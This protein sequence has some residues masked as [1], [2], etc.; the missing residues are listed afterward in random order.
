MLFGL[1]KFVFLGVRLGLACRSVRAWKLG[2]Y[3][4]IEK[5]RKCFLIRSR[6]C[7]HAISINGREFAILLPSPRRALSGSEIYDREIYNG[8]AA[9]D[10]YGVFLPKKSWIIAIQIYIQLY[11]RLQRGVIDA[12]T[13]STL[14]AKKKNSVTSRRANLIRC[15]REIRGGIR[16]ATGIFFSQ[17]R[18]FIEPWIDVF[19]WELTANEVSRARPFREFKLPRSRLSYKLEQTVGANL[20][21]LETSYCVTS[22]V[23][24][25]SRTIYRPRSLNS[26]TNWPMESREITTRYS[27]KFVN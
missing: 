18:F 12:F 23:V 3:R 1:N 4:T 15:K 9:L 27:S 22:S 25:E 26:H 6:R 2:V 7:A 5:K 16:V 11:S 20:R 13:D 21:N 8:G 14:K 24:A 17:R 10:R 19:C